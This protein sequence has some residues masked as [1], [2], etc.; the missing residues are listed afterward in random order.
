[1]ALASVTPQTTARDGAARI[2]AFMQNFSLE[3]MRPSDA[4]LDTLKTLA[5]AGTHVYLSSIPG[6]PAD[7]LISYARAIR[8]HGLE[9][10][11]HLAVR[12]FTSLNAIEDVLARLQ[13][14]AQI[15][16][17]LVIAGDRDSAEGPLKEAI[18]L[19]ESGLL[20]R[21]G[22]T[23]VGIAGYP[24]G[25]PRI[26]DDTLDRALAA[27]VEAAGQT[28]LSVHIVTQFT[29]EP[30]A[31]LR[32]LGR[33]RDSGIDPPVRIGMAGPTSLTALLR[34][35]KR[36]GVKASADAMTR[37]GGLLKQLVG[38]SAPDMIVRPVAEADADRIGDVAPHF[39]AFGG[40]GATARWAAAAAAGRVVLDRA[41]GFQVER[42]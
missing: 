17:A 42:G 24:D 8:Q 19:V 41:E 37:Q 11:P 5:P 16:R 4:D 15:R 29:F 30:A 12:N 28:G 22:V 1:M 13:G 9:P 35:A 34:Y 21:H 25:H 32:W 38:S 36:C 31:I 3:A 2:A 7:E 6:R 39:F 27:K 40:V 18:E 14:E 23:D 26:P 33:L 10:V 20:P